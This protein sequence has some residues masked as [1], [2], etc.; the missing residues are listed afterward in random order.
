MDFLQTF[1]IVHDPA[2]PLPQ[3]LDE[4]G[5]MLLHSGHRIAEQL[6]HIVGAGSAREH[7]HRERI[8]VA[9]W[10]RVRYASPLSNGEHSLVQ[11]GPRQSPSCA[12]VHENA[13]LGL[14]RSSVTLRFEAEQKFLR[15]GKYDALLTLL[16]EPVDL[17]ERPINVSP[18]EPYG[19]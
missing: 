4:W 10:V 13:V 3:F 7:I 16:G 11:P 9:V 12:W 5:V 14:R 15:N 18:C 19:V 17:S 6:C 2:C 1:A 8:P